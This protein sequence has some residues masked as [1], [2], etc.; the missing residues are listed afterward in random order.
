M[1]DDDSCSP[2]W[3]IFCIELPTP[4]LPNPLPIVPPIATPIVPTNF[5]DVSGITYI[6]LALH[7]LL[8]QNIGSLLLKHLH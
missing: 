6:A 4:M 7:H 8:V 1:V 3:N 5:Y 2:M